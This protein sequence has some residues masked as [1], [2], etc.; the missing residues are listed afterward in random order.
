MVEIVEQLLE[1]IRL[2]AGF[3]V[4]PGDI[5][6]LSYDDDSVSCVLS[7]SR[8]PFGMVVG[9][10]DEWGRVPVLCGLAIVKVDIYDISE[11]YDAGDLLYSNEAGRLTN[12]KCE[13]NSLLLGH[14][15]TPPSDGDSSMEINWI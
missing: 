1:P 14:V 12:K 6:S 4:F 5:I 10:P 8:N 13:D 2:P 3:E 9:P 15:L 7:N 11:K